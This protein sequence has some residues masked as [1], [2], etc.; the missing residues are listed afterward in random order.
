MGVERWSWRGRYGVL[1][2]SGLGF[3]EGY[4]WVWVGR[5]ESNGQRAS[6][7]AMGG[8]GPIIFGV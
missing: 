8:S 1:V 5:V 7:R 2:L 3:F 6:K 4:G